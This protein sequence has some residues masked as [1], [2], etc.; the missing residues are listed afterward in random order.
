MK[1]LE[2]IPLPFIFFIL[3]LTEIT[4]KNMHEASITNF[5][6]VLI[7]LTTFVLIIHAL[8]RK[9]V[10]NKL[11]AEL[12][13]VYFIFAIFLDYKIRYK[14]SKLFTLAKLNDFSSILGP[15]FVYLVPLLFLYFILKRFKL[16]NK[17][18]TSIK[19]PLVFLMLFKS[20]NTFFYIKKNTD[21]ISL[22]DKS[23][24]ENFIREKKITLKPKKNE[25]EKLPHIFLITLDG[26]PGEKLL[27]KTTSF[28]NS[29][30]YSKL[31]SKGG[32][33][34]KESYSNYPGTLHSISSLMN[35][36]Y[37][38]KNTSNNSLSDSSFL[39]YLISNNLIFN[40]MKKLGYIVNYF[41]NGYFSYSYL[42]TNYDAFSDGII[43]KVTL[44]ERNGSP[45]NRNT[46]DLHVLSRL[47]RWLAKLYYQI[48]KKDILADE[49]QVLSYGSVQRL[50][51]TLEFLSEFKG[52]GEPSFNYIH[53][54]SPH[55]PIKVN[56]DG[57][58]ISPVME[59]TAE[60]FIQEILYINKMVLETVEKIKNNFGDDTHII[61]MSDHGSFLGNSWVNGKPD[62]SNLDNFLYVSTP[63]MK[64]ENSLPDKLSLVN[65]FRYYLNFF[66]QEKLEILKS[67][68]FLTTKGMNNLFYFEENYIK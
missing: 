19:I 5:P 9:I 45:K 31:L 37:I 56:K 16:N 13:G 34:F 52:D 22:N 6:S 15:I 1:V 32:R 61:I 44:D 35:I 50:K 14:V 21:Y 42:A 54:M 53:L 12:L 25:N 65:L 58:A 66:H 29:G 24:Y 51:G 36:S 48:F 43:K 30:F 40:Y 64:F 27:S 23:V 2:R 57:D 20:V 4:G 38:D 67:R 41:N 11:L 7:F 18:F 63:H 46:F 55:A 49:R 60:V 39:R 62:L 10:G 8:L 17:L 68:F 28:N 26:Y 3:F 33:I 47:P 59:P